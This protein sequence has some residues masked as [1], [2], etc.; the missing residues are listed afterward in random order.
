MTFKG[1]QLFFLGL[2]ALASVAVFQV[3]Y[4]DKDNTRYEPFT[5]GYALTDVVMQTTDDTGR[6]VTIM[7]APSMT[8]YLDND[9]T[10]IEEPRV[11]FLAIDNRWQFDSPQAIYRSNKEQLYFP[12]QVFVASQD[13]PKVT[14][15]SSQ[16]LIDL[17]AQTGH[18][19][20]PIKVNQPAVMMQGVGA[21]ILFNLKEIEIL[22]QVYAEYLP[23]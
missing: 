16:L 23:R 3:F 21:N 19:P 22:D 18:T 5:K 13:E 8:H 11:T 4:A 7:R 12:E 10:V 1:K 6:I 2:L 15:K 17:I 14:L 9:Q 20:A